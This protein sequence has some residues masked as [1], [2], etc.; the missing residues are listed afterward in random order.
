MSHYTAY[1]AYQL[2][3][4][5]RT[6]FRSRTYDMF[7]DLNTKASKEA[8][9]RRADGWCFDR[10]AKQYD[11]K[12]LTDFFVA[13]RLEDRNYITE[14]LND[15]AHDTFVKYQARRQAISYHF[16]KDLD[17]LFKDG[18]KKPFQVSE[19]NY[20]LC[21]SEYLGGAVSSETMV[22]ANNYIPFVT[23]FDIELGKNDPLW[24]RVALKLCKYKPFVE[25]DRSKIKAI[26]KEKV[27]QYGQDD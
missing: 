26:L 7:R 6:H 23:K 14:L 1:G 25:Y 22:I 16:A 8:F 15:E 20:P 17:T 24:S 27:K 19:D 5:V 9:G 12:D 11:E 18:V 2:F 13:N 4:T 3:V 21:I 10:I